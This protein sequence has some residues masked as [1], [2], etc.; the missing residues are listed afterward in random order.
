MATYLPSF[1]VRESRAQSMIDTMVEAQNLEDKIHN[2]IGETGWIYHYDWVIAG[3]R[4]W[5]WPCLEDGQL[6]PTDEMEQHRLEYYFKGPS[7][8]CAYKLGVEYTE[9]KIR[10]IESVN[11]NEEK[12]WY[13]PFV[14]EYIA[15]CARG[16]CGYFVVLERFYSDKNLLVKCYGKRETPITIAPVVVTGSLIGDMPEDKGPM[17]PSKLKALKRLREEHYVDEVAVACKYDLLWK[18]GL[19][20]PEFWNLFVQCARCERV[21]TR[22][23]YPYGHRCHKRMIILGGSQSDYDTSDDDLVDGK[24][25]MSGDEDSQEPNAKR[26]RTPMTDAE[27]AAKLV[28]VDNLLAEYWRS[29]EAE[30]KKQ[31]EREKEIKLMEEEIEE[32][33][34]LRKE[35]YPQEPDSESEE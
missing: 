1:D 21:F 3:L 4:R 29:S 32:L 20:G 24:E 14:G 31:A 2:T 13:R 34:L 8:V 35:M 6:V 26:R 33:E 9:T 15:E 30:E 16:V 12:I 17:S 10:L 18:G 23:L 5:A 27:V 25:E 19:P 28:E 7:C 11:S 22:D